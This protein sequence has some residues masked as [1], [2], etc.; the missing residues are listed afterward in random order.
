MHNFIAFRGGLSY[1][2][3]TTRADAINNSLTCAGP[4]ENKAL[5]WATFPIC[6]CAGC[7]GEITRYV[8]WRFEVR[9]NDATATAYSLRG[10][11]VTK[12]R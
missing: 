12:R 6:P 7:R 5:P 1:D 11:K 4:E 2:G 9:G 3:G 10:C 8:A